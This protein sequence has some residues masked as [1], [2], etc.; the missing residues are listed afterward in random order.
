MRAPPFRLSPVAAAA[1]LYVQT[2]GRPWMLDW[3]LPRGGR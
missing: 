1:R 2:I 3:H